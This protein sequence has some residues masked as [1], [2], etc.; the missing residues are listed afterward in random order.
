MVFFKGLYKELSQIA[1]CLAHPI[2][3]E[4][5]QAQ[6]ESKELKTK[7]TQTFLL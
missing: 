6:V 1:K 3:R 2:Y 7:I 5:S 4:L